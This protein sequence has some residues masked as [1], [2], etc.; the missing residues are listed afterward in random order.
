MQA[1]GK[2][3]TIPAIGKY[4]VFV[5]TK[6]Q[7]EE[8]SS[9][10]ID[11]LSFNEAIDEQFRPHIIFN[12]FRFDPKDPRYSVPINAMKVRMRDNLPALIPRLVAYTNKSFQD[13]L[14]KK[15]QHSVFDRIFQRDFTQWLLDATRKKTPQAMTR[16]AQH[17]MG[18]MFGGAHQLPMLLSFA[19]Y[20]LCKHPEYIE[21]L[22]K[23]IVATRNDSSSSGYEAH[24][25]PLMDSFL[26]ETA[27]LN[28]TVILTMPRKVMYP[29]RFSDGTVVPKDNWLC[30]PQQAIM[31]DQ[32][33]YDDPSAFNGFRFVRQDDDGRAT[34][35][36]AGKDRLFTTPTFEFPLWG[37]VRRAWYV[38]TH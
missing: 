19:M 23:E 1:R 5:S 32:Q 21:P 16:L 17:V 8:A 9:A 15:G 7:V 37:P 29:F 10:P 12:G 35:S 26:K 18:L 22:T 31:E 24:D 2:L 28:P 4:V 34:A 33:Y 14:P 6:K 38:P 20:N 27:R 30:I 13:E 36:D 3:F 11:Q 25:M